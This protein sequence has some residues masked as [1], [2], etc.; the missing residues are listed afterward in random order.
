[1]TGIRIGRSLGVAALL[2]ALPTLAAAPPAPAAW[3]PP[4][5]LDDSGGPRLLGGVGLGGDAIVVTWT[6]C[7]LF[8]PD[9]C[10]GRM[11]AMART[12][13]IA[14]GRLGPALELS[15]PGTH[16]GYPRFAVAPNGDAVFVWSASDGVRARWLTAGVLGPILDVSSQWV[17]P[18]AIHQVVIGAGEDAVIA[19]TRIRGKRTQARTL[20][21]GGGLGPLLDIP[22]PG[23]GTG[24]PGVGVGPRGDIVVAWDDQ[25]C[26]CFVPRRSR[27]RRLLARSATPATGR[28]GPI[29]VLWR[30]KRS[31]PADRAIEPSATVDG[32][33]DALVR[34]VDSP[35][36]G[37]GIDSDRARTLS[38]RGVLGPTIKATVGYVAMAP[39]GRAVTI[40]LRRSRVR[41]RT[42]SPAGR[43]GAPVT[44]G[45]DGSTTSFAITPAGTGVFAWT[46]AD[47]VL[48]RSLS[49]DGRLSPVVELARGV[50]PDP[51]L[52]SF[53]RVTLAVTSTVLVA[54][55][56]P[57]DAAALRGALDPLPEALP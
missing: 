41:A 7:E 29:A 25:D 11:R 17:P 45:G 4:F 36:R 38:A 33:G 19:W 39:S 30:A 48:T 22:T 2:G 49:R 23:Q 55:W 40:W 3:S 9:G 35:A 18:Y 43:L 15:A 10:G 5:Q 27:H 57:R 52:G 14:T 37:G 54:A 44:V 51:R 12:R 13:S 8:A 50:D 31:R 47:R 6:A 28:I 42:I 34:W 20:S 21:A 32:D 56:Q 53:R 24:M 46:T 1:M 16:A 26:P